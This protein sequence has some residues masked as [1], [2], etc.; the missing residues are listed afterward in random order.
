[1]VNDDILKIIKKAILDK[2][3]DDVKVIDVKKRTPF[4]NY[5]ILATAN[6]VR[7]I[8]AIKDNVINELEKN[9]IKI[10]H[11]EGKANASW[12]LIDAYQYIINI[13][14]SAERQRI[15]LDSL[16]NNK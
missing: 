10:H 15:D 6:N 7:Q 3:G 4:A 13:F 1:M 5:Y 11:V 2:K 16:L 9:K 8:D 14:S 12:V